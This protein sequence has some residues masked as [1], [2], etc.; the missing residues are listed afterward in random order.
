MQRTME[1]DE[2]IYLRGRVSKLYRKDGKVRVLGTDTLTNVELLVFDTGSTSIS[3]EFST[4]VVADGLVEGATVFIDT[5][6]NGF[7]DCKDFNCSQNPD[8][9]VCGEA[10][11]ES[12]AVVP[13]PQP[14][15]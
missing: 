4:G 7:A 3:L 5:N 1:S 15:S 9:T 13:S 6:A 12:T 2:A 8:V 14:R 10:G 11:D